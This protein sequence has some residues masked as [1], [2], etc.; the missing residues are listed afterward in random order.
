MDST[1][2]HHNIH[3]SGIDIPQVDSE[4]RAFL[5]KSQRYLSNSTAF[6]NTHLPGTSPWEDTKTI[7]FPHEN[8]TP[9]K[10]P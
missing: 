8:R 7:S 10:A 5:K 3:S 6:L 9:K 1:N 2:G 4:G